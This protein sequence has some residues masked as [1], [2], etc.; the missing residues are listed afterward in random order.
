MIN[1]YI[2]LMIGLIHGV[3]VPLA[4]MLGMII[5]IVSALPNVRGEQRQNA[6]QL[7]LTGLFLSTAPS[8]LSLLF[9]LVI[10]FL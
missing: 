2:A 3:V 8:S 4:A 5:C 9:R 1:E 7:L 10:A 6:K